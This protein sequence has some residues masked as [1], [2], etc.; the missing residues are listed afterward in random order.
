MLWVVAQ[1]AALGM[2]DADAGPALRARVRRTER[3]AELTTAGFMGTKIKR[4]TE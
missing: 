3:E 2:D 1:A 4:S